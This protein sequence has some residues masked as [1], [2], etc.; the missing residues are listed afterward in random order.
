MEPRH[1]QAPSQT[2]RLAE[3]CNQAEDE[4]HMAQELA[5]WC[6]AP[7]H[8]Y[9]PWDL[10]PAVWRAAKVREKVEEMRREAPLENSPAGVAKAMLRLSQYMNRED[11]VGEVATRLVRIHHDHQY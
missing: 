8:N 7:F 2:Q 10:V 9:R 4:G 5:A 3:A 11:I 6:I 1:Y